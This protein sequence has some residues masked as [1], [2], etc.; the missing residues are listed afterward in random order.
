MWR[1]RGKTEDVGGFG[2]TAS[3]QVGKNP[4]QT[5]VTAKCPRLRYRMREQA[6][7]A[8]R[9]LIEF[10]VRETIDKAAVAFSSY[11][12]SIA[13]LRK[14]LHIPTL[15]GKN[16]LWTH[17]FFIKWFYIFFNFLNRANSSTRGSASTK[18]DNCPNEREF[19]VGCA[20]FVRR[21]Y[22]YS[23]CELH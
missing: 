13:K 22:P 3:S 12:Y 15:F 23:D 11:M 21:G 20:H 5:T 9:S 4:S 17:F 2:V 16:I 10:A 7:I 6:A 19:I 14:I 18:A 1:E 8:L